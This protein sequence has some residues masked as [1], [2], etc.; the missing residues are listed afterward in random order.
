MM[1]PRSEVIASLRPATSQFAVRLIV[2]GLLAVASGPVYA[3][4]D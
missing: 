2:F 3:Q 4:K 1:S